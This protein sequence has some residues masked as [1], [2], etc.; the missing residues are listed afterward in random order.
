[1]ERE[2]AIKLANRVLERPY[3]DPDD[4]LAVL[5]RQ[6]LRCTEIRDL[7]TELR[8]AAFDY[9]SLI[10]V[11]NFDRNDMAVLRAYERL[12]KALDDPFG[13]KLKPRLVVNN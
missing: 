9:A 4:D 12:R 2:D 5:A 3:A 10:Q 8:E 7:Y 6:F 11:E 1:M 13:L